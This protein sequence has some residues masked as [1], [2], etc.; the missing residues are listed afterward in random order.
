MWEEVGEV[1]VVKGR[2]GKLLVSNE[3]LYFGNVGIVFC[4]FIFVV[5][6][7]LF[8]DIIIFIVFIGNVR[9]KVRLIGLFVD[10]FWFNGVVVKYL[11][12]ENSLLV[13]VD[14]VSGFVGGVI[15]LVVI[16]LLQYVFLILMV[17]FYVCQ[18]V[19]FK[20]VGGKFIFQFYI[21]MI[22]VM[23]VFFGVKVEC[24][25]EDFNIYYIFQGF[26]KNFE[27]YVVESDVSLVMYFLVVVVIIG[28][29]CIIFNIG[30]ILFQGDVC[31][32]VDVF[33]F[34]GCMVEQIDIF[35]IVIGFF[36]GVF[37]VIFYV[38]MEFMIDVFLIV[39]VFV[40]VVL[41]IIQIIGI[42]N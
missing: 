25:V 34:M 20:L 40:V 23:M 29:I 21:D 31:F 4:F 6:F 10:V 16:I 11:E 42:V 22:I 8:I 32:V 1:F 41:G 27:E 33:C 18:L 19:V 7:C 5:V 14:V 35:I 36:V 9:M 26:Y 17:V 24:D 30:C 12:K 38:D 37:K 28:M 2:G 39:F 15:E 3:F 13:Q